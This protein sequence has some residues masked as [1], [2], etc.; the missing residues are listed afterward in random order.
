MQLTPEQQTIGRRNFLKAVAGVPALAGLGTAAALKGPVRGGPVRV[1]FIG[2]GGE[3]RVLLAQVDP[4]YAQVLALADINPT[5][6]RRPMR[7]LRRRSALR[8][9]AR[10]GF[11][12]DDEPH[13]W[14]YARWCLRVDGRLIASS[15]CASS[16]RR[17]CRASQGVRCR[18]GSAGSGARRAGRVWGMRREVW[19]WIGVLRRRSCRDLSDQTGVRPR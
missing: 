10:T 15:R 18:S 19:G 8:R 7:S 9:T 4:A 12:E 11:R 5:S 14:R 6:S 2:L 3:G 1:G 16:Q 17:P 13:R